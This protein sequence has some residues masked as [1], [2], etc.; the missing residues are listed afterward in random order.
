MSTMQA[1]CDLSRLDIN[2]ADKTRYADTDLLKYAN[3]AVAVVYQMRPDLKFGRYSTPTA[4]LGMTDDFPLDNAYR[5][6]VAAYVVARSETADDPFAV[7]QKAVQGM[8]EFMFG[9]GLT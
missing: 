2:D 9:L 5:S 8:K 4:D 6:P 3:D 1:I 7:E